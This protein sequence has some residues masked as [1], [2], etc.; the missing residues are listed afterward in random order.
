MDT[1]I[2]KAV[3][4]LIPGWHGVFV[5]FVSDGTAMSKS[6]TQ[7]LTF[8]RV[9][10]SNVLR[11]TERWFSPSIAPSKTSTPAT[12]P[13]QSRCSLKF[14]ILHWFV[15]CIFK[16]LIKPSYCGLV[17]GS[18]YYSRA[19]HVDCKSVCEVHSPLR[20]TAQLGQA[21]LPLHNVIT[22]KASAILS[23]GSVYPIIS[24]QWWLAMSDDEQ[25]VLSLGSLL[26]NSSFQSSMNHHS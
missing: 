17:N 6:G 23:E 26:R 9:C 10:F 19:V 11:H 20:N 8:L 22:N 16:E 3:T 1:C 14:E 21:L 24:V 12:L 13:D 2:Y 25:L 5:E 15:F 18:I 4:Q 7:G